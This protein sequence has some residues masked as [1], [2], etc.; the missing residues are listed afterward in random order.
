M[1]CALEQV[2]YAYLS[3]YHSTVHILTQSSTDH[4]AHAHAT[5]TLHLPQVARL[6]PFLITSL[7]RMQPYASS[8]AAAAALEAA[9]PAA[10]PGLVAVLAAGDPTDW[11]MLPHEVEGYKVGRNSGKIL[12]LHQSLCGSLLAA[13]V[14]GSCACVLAQEQLQ[15]LSRELHRCWLLADYE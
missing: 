2:L 8:P 15:V 12:C 13:C 5:L 6:V 14:F 3:L 1:Q 7:E 10:V 9:G 11:P 4:T